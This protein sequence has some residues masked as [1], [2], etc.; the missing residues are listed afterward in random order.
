MKKVTEKLEV[1]Q[2]VILANGITGR[3]IGVDELREEVEIAYDKV[4]ADAYGYEG[5]LHR[6]MRY[7]E[8]HLQPFYLLGRN[9][10]G[11]KDDAAELIRDME[12]YKNEIAML[13]QQLATLRRQ[14]FMMNERMVPDWR[15]RTYKTNT[16]HLSPE[17]CPTSDESNSSGK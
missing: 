6:R 14:L 3:I 8:D 16:S 5:K 2:K 4:Y 9:L 7:D 10:I 12:F 11:N 15:E 1:G 13:N 17:N